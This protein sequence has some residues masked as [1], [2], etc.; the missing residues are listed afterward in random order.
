MT[1]LRTDHMASDP[2]MEKTKAFEHG[3]Q[4]EF[5][6]VNSSKKVVL[7]KPKTNCTEVRD[8][9]KMTTVGFEKELTVVLELSEGAQLT[10][11][12]FLKATKEVCGSV[13]ACRHISKDKYEVTVGTIKA[14][15]RLLDGYCIGGVRVHARDISVDELVVSFM[16]LPAYIMDEEIVAK[17]LAWGVSAVSEVR[18]RMWPGTNVAD[19]TRFVRVRFTDTVQSLPYSVRFDTAAGPE[20][21]RVIHDRQVRVCRGCLQPGHILRE[22]P[23]FLCRNCGSQGHYA[24][25]C[26]AQRAPK[27]RECRMFRHLCACGEGDVEGEESVC[28][29]EDE[30]G[31]EV[32]RESG[33]EAVSVPDTEL[34]A[35]EEESEG[36]GELEESE[37]EFSSQELVSGSVQV[38]GTGKAGQQ[39]LT[40]L[41]DRR[42]GARESL[43]PKTV[44]AEAEPGRRMD[45]GQASR[46]TS[47]GGDAARAASSDPRFHSDGG[48]RGQ[49]ELQPTK[50][51]S[52]T[53]DGEH[54]A[55]QGGRAS[56]SS[57][58]CGDGE[59]GVMESTGKKG[60]R[61]SLISNTS[62]LPARQHVIP[63]SSTLSSAPQNALT[64]IMDNELMD[65]S[66]VEIK[67]R[68][69]DVDVSG[70]KKKSK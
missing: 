34:S 52:V 48:K 46:L 30:V 51:E 21:F 6:S 9:R 22:C 15:E 2:C 16:G 28:G 20:Y 41:P 47:K 37:G 33:D 44:A 7:E 24:R 58:N 56:S 67:K 49:V 12:A 50:R 23:D 1:D 70:M 25:E 5:T 55:A 42:E 43:P 45:A 40:A 62:K 60:R 26:V 54:T 18:R 57:A 69:A 35:G 38:S 3:Q 19:G 65:F 4:K 53:G 61:I 31:G 27:C 36:V 29:G 32:G 11:L 66:S 39:L 17:L 13:L 14:K 59:A 8:G 10:P 63:P 64:A 68:L